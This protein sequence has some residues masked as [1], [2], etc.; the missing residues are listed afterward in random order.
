[1]KKYIAFVFAAA[2][3]NA[4]ADKLPTELVHETKNVKPPLVH[5]NQG[6]TSA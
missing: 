2:C 3:S 5:G 6:Q 4:Y 1:M